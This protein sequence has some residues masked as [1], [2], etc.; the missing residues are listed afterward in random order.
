MANTDN[1]DLKAFFTQNLLRGLAWFAVILLFFF[2]VD[3]FFSDFLEAIM[4]SL[5]DRLYWIFILFF[6]SEVIIGIIPPEFIMKLFTVDNS[7]QHYVFLILSLSAVS[8][9]GGIVAYY[10]GRRFQR[11]RLLLGLLKR[12]S[13]RKYFHYYR[14]FGGILIVIAAITPVPYGLVALLSGSAGFTFSKY[15][16]FNS[17]RFLRFVVYGYIIWLQA[18]AG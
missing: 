4:N 17:P 5:K 6:S 8:Y 7:F 3:F 1:Q 11:S 10:I 14:R 18:L 9:I 13:N 16:I 12:E 2:F 15:M